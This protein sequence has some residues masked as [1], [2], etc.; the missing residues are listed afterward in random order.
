M[1][2]KRVVCPPTRLEGHAEGGVLTG[3]AYFRHS[4]GRAH[5][6]IRFYLVDIV[7]IDEGGTVQ[8]IRGLLEEDHFKT[9]VER[10]CASVDNTATVEEHPSLT[11]ALATGSMPVRAMTSEECC[12]YICPLSLA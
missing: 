7:Y 2:T 10:R 12:S 8:R 6:R 11:G 1:Q 9:I 5:R 3:M 4:D